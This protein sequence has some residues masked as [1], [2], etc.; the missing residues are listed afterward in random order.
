MDFFDSARKALSDLAG[1]TS[2]QAELAR[3]KLDLENLRSQLEQ[4]EAQAGRRVHDMYR[5]EM[6]NDQVLVDLCVR[7][8]AL[9]K[10]MRDLQS[11]IEAVRQEPVTKERLC[12]SCGKPVDKMAEFCAHCGNKLPVCGH[13]YEPLSM[14]EAV[15]PSCGEKTILAKS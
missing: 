6:V 10:Q 7:M 9:E 15:C 3:L 11:R 8:E 12:A 1:E 14:G 2:K 4:I 13:C 5:Q